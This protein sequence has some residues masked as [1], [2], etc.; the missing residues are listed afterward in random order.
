MLI[1]TTKNKMITDR[2]TDLIAELKSFKGKRIGVI[3]H[4]RPD[5]DCIGAQ[6]A[7]CRWFTK[8]GIDAKAFNDDELSP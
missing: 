6:V 4:V 2:I 1:L 8:H 7:L 5:A 3:S